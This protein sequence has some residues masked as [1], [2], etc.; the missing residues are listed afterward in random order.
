[1]PR[2]TL[3]GTRPSTPEL[4]ALMAASFVGCQVRKISPVDQFDL[5]KSW[6]SRLSR[7]LIVAVRVARDPRPLLLAVLAD[8]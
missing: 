4:S 7:T 8:Y 3:G 2:G 6:E 5:L 1:M